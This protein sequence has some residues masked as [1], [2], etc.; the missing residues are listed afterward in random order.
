[1]AE[2]RTRAD[3]AQPHA[4][5]HLQ[6]LQPIQRKTMILAHDCLSLAQ[7]NFSLLDTLFRQIAADKG[8]RH[9]RHLASL[10]KYLADEWGELLGIYLDELRPLIQPAVTHPA[11]VEAADCAQEAYQRHHELCALF[12]AIASTECHDRIGNL[13][14]IALFMGD[15]LSCCMD[16]QLEFL[17]LHIASEE[18]GRAAQ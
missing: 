15:R 7:S 14:S 6:D 11:L 17:D 13:C 1:M 16:E 12:A 9:V 3:Q 5:V 2:I 8:S 10:G 4:A 18:T